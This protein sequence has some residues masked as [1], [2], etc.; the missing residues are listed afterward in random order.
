[1]K[2]L[3][4]LCI[5]ALTLTLLTSCFENN[6][7]DVPET[8]AT[9]DTTVTEPPESVSDTPAETEA[10]APS[11]YSVTFEKSAH[12]EIE[13]ISP[14]F[15]G[16]ESAD[17]L[18]A[19][20][21]EYSSAY[22]DTLLVYQYQGEGYC[23]LDRVEL[24]CQSD[25]FAS[26]V[27]IGSC[28]TDGMAHPHVF[29]YTVNLDISSGEILEFEDIIS[30]FDALAEVFKDGRFS[31]IETDNPALNAELDDISMDDRLIGY[32]SLYE[33]Y[34]PVYFMKDG[35]D[36]FLVLSLEEVYA[37]GSFADYRINA[38]DIRELLTERAISLLFD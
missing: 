37:L 28:Y 15:S 33:I 35:D 16:C 11:A 8:A 4:L 17:E 7:T 14:V 26:F 22:I 20:V 38:E 29:T 10:A 19:A 34:P 31:L 3:K 5:C 9:T 18:T 27:C 25:R 21:R 24:T 23:S 1:M 36:I 13:I 6:T 12:G 2:K 32:S 30:D